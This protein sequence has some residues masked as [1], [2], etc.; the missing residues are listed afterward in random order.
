VKKF[1]ISDLLVVLKGYQT[2]KNHIYLVV[3]KQFNMKEESFEITDVRVH[4][5]LVYVDIKHWRDWYGEPEESDKT[6]MRFT[7]TEEDLNVQ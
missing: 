5:N 1:L 7:F 3:S 4:D 6:A 2:Y